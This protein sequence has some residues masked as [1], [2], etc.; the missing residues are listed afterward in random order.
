[1]PSSSPVKYAAHLSKPT[2]WVFTN[3]MSYKSS[4]D[5][6]YGIVIAVLLYACVCD[7]HSHR[8]R[9]GRLRREPLARQELRR[10]VVVRV[11]VDDLDAELGVLQP[12]PA[13]GALLRA[14]RAGRRLRVR[15][16]EHDHVA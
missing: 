11:D 2:V 12:L 3:S 7:R 15:R 16:P 4:L 5:P 1:M 13:H 6:T 10:G 8:D 9:G 14:V